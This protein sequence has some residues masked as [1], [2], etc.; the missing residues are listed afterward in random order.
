MIAYKAKRNEY[1]N[2]VIDYGTRLARANNGT[3]AD[4]IEWSQSGGIYKRR[5]AQAR[6]DWIAN[7][8]KDDVE[9][10]QATI[11]HI[12]GSSMVVWMERLKQDLDSIQ[13]NVLGAFGYPFFPAALLPGGFARSSGWLKLSELELHKKRR[14]SS[15]SRDWGAS[16]GLNLGF[17][18]IGGSGGGSRSD[19]QV[20]F[21]QESFGID[22]EYTQIEIVRPWFN[23]NFFLS[24]GWK[25]RDEFIRDHNGQA[26][27]SDGK[28]KPQGLMI[29]YPTKAL[30]IRNL[31]I[32]SQSLAS[33]MSKHEDDVHGGGSVGWGPFSLG[34]HY[35]QRNRRSES[36][37]DVHAASFTVNGLQLVGFLSALFP[38][39]ANPDPNVKEWI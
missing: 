31:T 32:T 14:S 5:A 23:P 26:L 36:N 8:Y 37:L 11:D 13:D 29:G 38:Y 35:A 2:A 15:S 25:P 33:F 10:A 34:G 30:F 1:E 12:T 17:V 9:K 16:G 39:S 19:H 7:G 3:S 4:L 6:G 28:E 18:S 21:G 24:R 22:F 20:S 27:H